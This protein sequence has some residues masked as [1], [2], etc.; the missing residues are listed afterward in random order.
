MTKYKIETRQFVEVE[1]TKLSEELAKIKT[2]GA[3]IIRI[4]EVKETQELD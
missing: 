1:D 2:V 3:E 4:V